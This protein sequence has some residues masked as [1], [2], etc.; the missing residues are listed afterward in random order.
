VRASWRFAE[1]VAVWT[2]IKSPTLPASTQMISHG[3]STELMCTDS[4]DVSKLRTPTL[5]SSSFSALSGKLYRITYTNKYILVARNSNYNFRQLKQMLTR[6][7]KK[8]FYRSANDIFGKVGRIASEEVVYY[9][10]LP[11]SASAY[12]SSCVVLR[13]VH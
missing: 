2:A 5:M 1:R 7:R 9:R 12:L 4:R 8:S 10:S 6:P 11:P 13:S 3:L